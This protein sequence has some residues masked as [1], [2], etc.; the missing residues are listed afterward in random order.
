MTKIKIKADFRNHPYLSVKLT[1]AKRIKKR[2]P[3]SLPWIEGTLN[4]WGQYVGSG[5]HI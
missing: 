3:E 5:L 4:T 1:K 2:L